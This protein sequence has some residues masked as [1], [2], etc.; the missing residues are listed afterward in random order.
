MSS[1]YFFLIQQVND[2]IILAVGVEDEKGIE[3]E[4]SLCTGMAYILS[5]L[6]LKISLFDAIINSILKLFCNYF[7]LVSRNTNN[8]YVLPLYPAALINLLIS[9]SGFLKI[10]YNF[11]CSLKYHL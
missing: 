1:H 8:S 9:S 2:Q 4:C 10:P 11:L 7:L 5:N 3:S 6:F